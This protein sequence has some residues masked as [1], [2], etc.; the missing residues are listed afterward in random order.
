MDCAHEQIIAMLRRSYFAVDGLWF[1][2]VEKELG[3]E[4]ALELDER[5]WRVMPKIQARKARELLCAADAGPA[6]MAR[7][8][9]LKFAAEGHAWRV[10][11]VSPQ[12][13]EIVVTRCPWR[14]VLESAQRTHLGPQI[15]DRICAA[16]G[17]TWAAEFGDD[18]EFEMAEAICRGD[19]QCRFVFR[20]ID[21]TTE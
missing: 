9:A 4:R 12:Q 15:A 10:G 5:V 2:M 13:A 3:L 14:E 7:C 16:E 18:I 6:T 8:M 11:A 20:R 1:V 17:A 19:G 21:Q